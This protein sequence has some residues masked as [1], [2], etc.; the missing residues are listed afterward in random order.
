METELHCLELFTLEV[1]MLGL[2]R[3]EELHC[4]DLFNAGKETKGEANL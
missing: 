4:L 3:E 2:S 1:E